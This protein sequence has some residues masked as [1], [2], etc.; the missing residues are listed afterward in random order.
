[1]KLGRRAEY[2]LKGVVGN[3]HEDHDTLIRNMVG[4]CAG[5]DNIPPMVT[6]R[7]AKRVGWRC[8]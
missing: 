2:Y 4:V 1:M 5:Q 6:W 3:S 8:E 7:L